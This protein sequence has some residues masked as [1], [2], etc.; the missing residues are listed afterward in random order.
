MP[1]AWHFEATLADGR[2][3][4]EPQLATHGHAWLSLMELARH[5]GGLRSLALCGASVRVA[6][7][8]SAQFFHV[9]RVRCE[10]PEGIVSSSEYALGWAEGDGVAVVLLW[11][12]ADGSVAVERRPEAAKLAEFAIPG[13]LTTART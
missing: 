12:R 5:A 1:A 2:V 3:V 8:E 13:I 6:L 9:K 11:G 7:P 10:L 4:R